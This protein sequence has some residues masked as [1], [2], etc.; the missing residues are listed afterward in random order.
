MII[1]KLKK[2]KGLDLA[3]RGLTNKDEWKSGWQR[4]WSER[5]SVRG[6]EQEKEQ[7]GPQL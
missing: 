3:A 5:K 2:D 1:G 6:K 7:N 4:R